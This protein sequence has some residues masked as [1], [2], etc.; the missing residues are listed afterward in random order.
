MMAAPRRTAVTPTGSVKDFDPRAMDQ[1]QLQRYSR[2]ILLPEIDIEGQE[3]LNQATVM[4]V[5]AGGL[6]SP[7]ATY[8]ATSGV[9]HLIICDHD[10]VDLS[11]LQRQTLHGTADVGRPKAE[12][13]RERLLALNPGI[14]VTAITALMDAVSMR[15]EAA[16]ADLVV[17]ASD[18]FLTRYALSEACIATRRPLVMGAAIRMQGQVALFD[19]RSEASPCLACLYPHSAEEEESCAAMGVFAPLTGII[20]SLMAAVTLKVLLRLGDMLGGRLLRFDAADLS[21]RESRL[22]KDPECPVCA[23]SHGGQRMPAQ[24]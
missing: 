3:R 15:R 22:V 19:H 6:G 16:R 9:G 10:R 18:N 23:P 17:D 8:L 2:H 4:L 20:G 13:A 1:E 7:A 5:G 24:V 12:S 11:N 14:E 21:W